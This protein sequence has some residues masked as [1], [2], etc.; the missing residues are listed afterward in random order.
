MKY[1]RYRLRLRDQRL[2]GG[3]G[4]LPVGRLQPGGRQR[5]QRR[6]ER[7]QQQARQA[8]IDDDGSPVGGS[9][10]HYTSVQTVCNKI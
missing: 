3:E 2:R 6:G 10:G 1:F 8:E 9:G 7:E 5:G 4:W